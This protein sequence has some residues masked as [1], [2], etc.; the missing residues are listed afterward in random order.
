MSRQHTW[1]Y[2]R[3][4]EEAGLIRREKRSNVVFY[5]LT[6]ESKNLLTLCEGTVFP[7]RLHRLDKCQVAYEIVAD[8]LVP[9]DFKR[10]RWL[11]G[12]LCWALS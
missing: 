5:E 3:K 9:K 1:Y 2:V 6:E 10:W 8:G 7:A 11:I 4:L 12:R